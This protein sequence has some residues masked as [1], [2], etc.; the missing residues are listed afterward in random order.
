MIQED[1]RDHGLADWYGADADAG[2][3][4]AFGADLNFLAVTIDAGAGDED[5]AGWLHCE[6][7]N[8]R[9]ATGDTA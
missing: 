2:I 7:R 3:V 1:N 5:G 4:A 8:N 6:P 9:L